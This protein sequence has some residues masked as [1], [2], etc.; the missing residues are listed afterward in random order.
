MILVTAASGQSAIPSLHNKVTLPGGNLPFDQILRLIT[1]QTGI[2]FS[3]NTQKFKPSRII[4]VR[5]G[6]QRV[7]EL[8]SEIK[9][10]TGID[11]TLLGDHIIFIDRPAAKA[12][13][14]SNVVTVR[15]AGVITSVS[16]ATN[17][18]AMKNAITAAKEETGPVFIPNPVDLASTDMRVYP[19]QTDIISLVKVNAKSATRKNQSAKKRTPTRSGFF[20][21]AGLTTD[22]TF[23]INPSIRAGWPFLYGIARWSTNFTVSGFRYGVGGALRLNDRWQAGLMATTGVNSKEY[24]ESINGS[25]NIPITIKTSLQKIRLLAETKIGGHLQ[26]QFGPVLNILSTKYY[27]PLGTPT[28][29]FVSESD[30][31][32]YIKP[33]YTIQ[34]TYSPISAQ[35]TK[36]WVG[37]QLGLFYAIN[38]RNSR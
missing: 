14:V 33:P 28:P 18:A 22:E 20:V 23:Y 32:Q 26:L 30:V 15:K 10:S 19:I 13:V 3:L 6:I 31:T 7:D 4:H 36:V 34:D 27:N 8:L 9:N 5:K 35:N 12:A 25:L 2:K 38:F 29:L 37:L 24:P 1:Q 16:A 17:A 11:Y 21:D